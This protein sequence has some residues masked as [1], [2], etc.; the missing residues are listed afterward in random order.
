MSSIEQVELG[1]KEAR[2]TVD[3]ATSVKKL[4]R[5]RDFKA[6]VSQGY[7]KEE[8]ARLV[9]LKGNPGMQTPEHQAAILRQIDSISAFATYLDHLVRFGEMAE[10]AIEED[11]ET[12][13]QMEEEA[14]TAEFTEA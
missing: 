1:I 6:V 2:K 14:E 10:Q 4:Q 5:N 11:Q 8:A 13:R 7:F 3:L 9:H 12:L